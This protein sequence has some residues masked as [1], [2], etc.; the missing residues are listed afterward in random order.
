[1]TNEFRKSKPI[2]WLGG[3]DGAVAEKKHQRGEK[4]IGFKGE[5]QK[6]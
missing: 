2:F 5:E 6:A 3:G 1:V 4:E